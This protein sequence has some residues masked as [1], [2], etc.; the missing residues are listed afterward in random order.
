MCAIDAGNDPPQLVREGMI[1]MQFG[2]HAPLPAV[3]R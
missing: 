1:Q 2:T 3:S